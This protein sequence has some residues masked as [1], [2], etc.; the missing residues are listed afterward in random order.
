MEKQREKQRDALLFCTRENALLLRFPSFCAA[1]EN[2]YDFG[3][4]WG[5]GRGTKNQSINQ[6]ITSELSRRPLEAE[7]PGMA[8]IRSQAGRLG[9]QLDEVFGKNSTLVKAVPVGRR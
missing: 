7:I 8:S 4:F 1:G 2:F 3:C 5:S 6:K 9:T